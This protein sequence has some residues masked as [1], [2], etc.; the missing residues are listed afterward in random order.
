MV[1][2][3]THFEHHAFPGFVDPGT[4][5]QAVAK[6]PTSLS[7]SVTPVF[8]GDPGEDRGKGDVK[9]MTPRRILPQHPTNLYI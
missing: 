8:P 9:H 4:P 6:Q 5:S 1:T 3:I 7:H 2:T